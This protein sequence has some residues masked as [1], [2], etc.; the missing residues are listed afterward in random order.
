MMLQR[1][2]VLIFTSGVMS[3]KTPV[4]QY[5]ADTYPLQPRASG[6]ILVSGYN[7]EIALYNLNNNVLTKGRSWMV[8]P[9][10]TWIEQAGGYFWAIHE[11]ND[12]EGVDGGAVS[13]WELVDGDLQRREVVSLQS[14]GPAHLLVD[15]DHNL[16]ITSNYGGG[17]VT[18]VSIENGQLSEVTQLLKYGEGCRDASH[19]H[20]AVRQ[21]DVVWVM[22]LGC[23]A[24]YSYKIEGK[25][26]KEVGK[27][28]LEA[29]SG[30]RHMVLKGDLAFLAC[31][32]KNYVKVYQVNAA[33]GDLTLLQT[34][35]LAKSDDNYG[36]EI[37]VVDDFVYASSRGDGII[38]VFKIQGNQLV[39]IQELNLAGTW[40]RAVAI[41]DDILLAADQY[42]DSVQIVSR[43]K[44][45]GL[46]SP[47][48][49]LSTPAGPAFLMFYE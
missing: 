20:Q 49:S 9:N 13:R 21:G 46:L 8:D 43:D 22:D 33:S 17:S 24:V 14:G 32:L 5:P 48:G 29:G 23:D 6:N 44:L 27:T 28:S 12:F 35:P 37:L 2:L 1:L 10:L 19:P 39:N 7:A 4:P 26:L 25:T 15:L 3:M 31:E 45:T 16:A 47:G 42:G 40:P 11:V 36:A 41:K 18:V 30:P 34:L 38:A